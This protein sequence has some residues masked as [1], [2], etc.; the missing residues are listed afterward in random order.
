VRCVAVTLPNAKRLPMAVWCGT[1]DSEGPSRGQVYA[2]A[3]KQVA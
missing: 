2:M 3:R 1:S